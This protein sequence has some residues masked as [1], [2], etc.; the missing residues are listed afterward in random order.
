MYG[1]LGFGRRALAKWFDGPFRPVPRFLAA[2]LF[3]RGGFSWMLSFSPFFPFSLGGHLM[4]QSYEPFL[5]IGIALAA[6]LL[7]GFEREQSQP[8]DE[9]AVGFLGGARTFPLVAL[10]GALSV[11]LGQATWFFFP[12]LAFL[13]L[14]GLVTFSYADDVRKERDRGLTTEVSLLVTFFIGAL[15]ATRNWLLPDGRKV[16]VVL[17]CAVVVTLLLS[18]KPRLNQLVRHVSRDDLYA[19]LKFLII[20]VLILPLLP[21]VALGP[22]GALNPF[23]IGLMVSLIAGVSFVGY[24]AIRVAGPGR[25]L[26]VTALI[27]GLV[28]STA[29]TLASAGRAAHDRAIVPAA[30]LAIVLASTIMVARVLLEAAVVFT[31]LFLPLLWPAGLML[32]AGIASSLFLY[33]RSVSQPVDWTAVKFQNPFE[34]GS[35]VKSGLLFA[36][37]LLL[38]KAAQKY[39]GTKGMYLAALFAGT[40]DVDAITLSTASLA[41]EGLPLQVAVTTITLG[42]LANTVV[43]GAMAVVLAGLPLARPVL[44]PFGAMLLGAAVG[45]VVGRLV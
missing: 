39:A 4:W 12:L 13:G 36:A 19:T 10:F 42:A 16:I 40:T 21:N 35:A 44:I 37:V 6:G 5:S 45:L 20:A 1:F 27:G 34:L 32:L 9:K 23:Q 43:K 33:R 30:S 41:R 38:A 2:G 7:I 25:G 11:L 24:V 28:S 15:S 31:P 26:A 14:L 22:L 29:V 17:A 8:E 18:A 3:R